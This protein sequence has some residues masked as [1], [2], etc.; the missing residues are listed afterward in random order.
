[1][2]KKKQPTA[3]TLEA[4]REKG[5]PA[6]VV[7]KWIPGRR[8]KAGGAPGE[9]ELNPFG[10]RKD[11][12]GCIDILALDGQ[13]GCLGVQ[14]CAGGDVA[15]RAKKAMAEPL[16]LAWLAAGNRFQVWGWREVWVATGAKTK[17]QRWRPRVLE[18]RLVLELGTDGRLILEERG[19]GDEVP[20]TLTIDLPAQQPALFEERP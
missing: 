12:F 2:T 8:Q 1:M 14:A 13:T 3:R 16:L 19:E 7:E 10:V 18:I 15:T 9:T 5:W 20:Q 6:Q 11:L 17:A 4:L